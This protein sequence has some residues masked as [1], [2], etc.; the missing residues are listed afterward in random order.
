MKENK[1]NYWGIQLVYDFLLMI[2]SSLV[3]LISLFHSVGLDT[4]LIASLM[5]IIG[6]KFLFADLK[7]RD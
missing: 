6:C 5:F 7:A 2:P 4:E 3:I 1:D